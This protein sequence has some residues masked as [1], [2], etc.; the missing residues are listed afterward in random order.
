MI[1][2]RG[3]VSAAGEADQERGVFAAGGADPVDAV[4]ADRDHLGAIA[5]VRR[6]RVE[7][8]QGL[9]GRSPTRSAPVGSRSRS[10]AVQPSASRSRRA[11][12]AML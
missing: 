4:S 9:R 6:D 8:R 5:D 2:R 3:D 1:A 12:G 11:A 7:F 10:G